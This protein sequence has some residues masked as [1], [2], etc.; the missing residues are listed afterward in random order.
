MRSLIVALVILSIVL[1]AQVAITS[2]ITRAAGSTI[3]SARTLAEPIDLAITTIEPES[4]DVCE[5]LRIEDALRESDANVE[6]TVASGTQRAQLIAKHGITKLPAV[7]IEGDLERIKIGGR[8]ENNAVIIESEPP[9]E[10]AMNGEVVGIVRYRSLDP[11]CDRCPDLEPVLSA[12]EAQGVPLEASALASPQR[13]PAIVFDGLERYPKVVDSLAARGLTQTGD[14]MTLFGPPP[15]VE[16]GTVHGLVNLTILEADSSC[17]EC[18]DPSVHERVL[19]SY[20][21]AVDTAVYLSGEDRDE[22]IEKYSI[23]ELPTAIITGDVEAYHAFVQVWEQVGSAENGTYVFRDSSA[24][25]NVQ[26]QQV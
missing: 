24:L 17:S 8:S 4:C 2:G 5:P 15:Y 22:M 21:L 20:G 12:L 26:T 11:D 6:S 3:E 16:N 25:G 1:A 23:E 19:A 7:V 14:T 9:Y 10:D 18:Y 13:S